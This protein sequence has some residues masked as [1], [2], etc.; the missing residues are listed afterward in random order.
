M[1]NYNEITGLKIQRNFLPNDFKV[2][3][4]EELEPFYSILLKSEINNTQDLKIWIKNKNEIDSIVS[5]D[6][7]WRY[8]KMNCNT[9]AKELSDSFEYFIQNIEPKLSPISNELNKKLIACKFS[10][11]LVDSAY[12]IYLRSIKRSIQ[13]FREENVPLFLEINTLQQE[14]GKICSEMLVQINDKEY[15]LQQAAKFLEITDRNIRKEVY[16]TIAN[17]R[18]KDKE[19]LDELLNK[20]IKLRHQVALNSGYNNFRDYMHDEL[21]RFDYGVKDCLSFHESIKKNSLFILNSLAEE[22]KKE[23]NI[24]ELFPYDLEVDTSGKD[25]LKP[26]NTSQDLIE[27]TI[28]T[29]N[30]LNPFIANCIFTMQKNNYLDLESRKNKAPGGF[31]YPLMESGIPFIYMNSVGSQK[32]L[33][34]MVHEGGHALHS[35]LCNDL[36]ISAFKNT[37]MEVAELASM[38][39]ELLS[40]EYWDVFFE[41]KEDLKRAKIDQLEKVLE[42]LPWVAAVDKFQHWIYLNP[43]HTS[44]ERSDK[45]NEIYDEF[46][47]KVISFEG[48]ENFKKNMWQKQLH[49]YEVPFYYIEYGIAQLGAI[50]IWRN[51]KENKETS[52]QKYMAA[53]K[54]GYT[55]TIKEIYAIAGIKF[56][57]SEE[58]VRELLQFTFEQLQKLKNE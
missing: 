30:R 9:S 49:I 56:D 53:L 47:S 6:F 8:I 11:E 4:W 57:F 1:Q 43:D 50:A 45:W 7:A 27:K 22:R 54:I 36:E 29:F 26:F 3:T 31:N 40:M 32:D 16:E 58:Y 39:M 33:V 44:I 10:N 2:T 42:T 24:T 46:S 34:T 20:L 14:Y 55:S 13:L 28:K 12:Q 15:T 37:P 19:K 51:F 21:G 38:S 17:R 25:A 52:I 41:N 5:E 18:F 35:F 48:Y 23:L